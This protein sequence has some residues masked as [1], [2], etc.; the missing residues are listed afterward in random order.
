MKGN[1]GM[2]KAICKLPECGAPA[3]SKTRCAEHCDPCSIDG[4]TAP[5]WQKTWCKMHYARWYRNGD[6]LHSTRPTFGMTREQAFRHYMPEPPPPGPTSTTGCW[7]WR[8]PVSNDYGSYKADTGTTHKAH[9]VSYELHVR[10]IPNGK[11]IRH[12]CDTPLCVQPAHLIPGSDA[13]NNRDMMERGRNR[14]PKGT[15]QHDAKLTDDSVREI[16]TA[17]ATGTVTQQALADQYGVDQT[18]ISGVVRRKLW[19]HVT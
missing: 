17:Y 12:T 4:C 5:A 1:P 16:R 13:D 6:P 9:R 8:G 10:P 15:A 7:L 14:Q 18:L 3:H 2:S 19:K 11:L